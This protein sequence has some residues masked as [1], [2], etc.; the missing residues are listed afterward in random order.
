MKRKIFATLGLACLT[1][2]GLASCGGDEASNS[3]SINLAYGNANRGLLYNQNTPIT[4]Q[5]GTTVSSGDLKPVWQ[6][7]EKELSI[8]I[9]VDG[10]SANKS[11]DMMSQEATNG[12]KNANIYGGTNLASDFMNYGANNGFFVRLD[13]HLDEM[14][15]F[16]AYL[17]ENPDIRTAITAYDGHIYHIPYIAEIGNYARLYHVRKTWITDLLDEANPNYDTASEIDASYEPFYTSSHP[18]AKSIS[19]LPTKK[20]D[21]NIIEIMNKLEVKNG[22]TLTEALK[23]YI[24]DNYDY[25]KLSDFYL[26]VD[27]AY[28]IDE[29]VALFRCVKTNP[30]Y[31]TGVAD[32]KTYPF[33]T[34]QGS[35]REEVLRFGT[36]FDGVKA[37]GSDSYSSRWAFDENG[38]PYYTYGTE[39]FYN[40]VTYLKT[41]NDEG[42]IY[43]DS[44]SD[45]NNTAN[46]R[47][48]L[49]GSDSQ[50]NQK[51]FGF[52]CYDFTASTTA[53]SLNEDIVAILP[54]I[55]EV[56]GVWQHYV[57]N[58]RVIKPDGWAVASSSSNEELTQAFKL[59]NYFF[60][61]EGYQVQ[62]YGLPDMIDQTK[63][64][65]GPDGKEYPAY[66]S[67]IKEQADIHAKGDYSTFLRDVMGSLIP[68]GYQ[69]EI[70]FEYQYTSQRG[71]DAVA[72]YTEAGVG[73]PSYAGEGK[74]PTSGGNPNYYKLIPPAFSLNRNQ[75]SQVQNLSIATDTNFS[76]VIFNIIR[77]LD[78]SEVAAPQTYAEYLKYFKDAGLDTYQKVYIDAYKVMSGRE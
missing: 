51:N 10:S 21:Q 76:E 61:D 40:V 32:A 26:S 6:Y 23:T 49:Y 19:G 35:Y 17:E 34:R 41:W 74:Q 56:N 52:M 44:L 64:F 28:D 15:D 3:L 77:G 39:E 5:D 60:T 58:T 62:N 31:L 29:L 13:E 68:I 20:T 75:Q 53:D 12:F 9:T 33:F 55:A 38:D 22:K 27:A 63:K 69:K 72:L 48:L 50:Q 14:P 2:L 16:A 66:T 78:P 42:L 4:L 45:G 11:A 24:K 59:L 8:D 65:E 18:R 57:D 47:S 70:G 43:G 36:Y 67:W 7:I 54:P 71:L 25:D 46:D 1:V 73:Q 30:V 37:H